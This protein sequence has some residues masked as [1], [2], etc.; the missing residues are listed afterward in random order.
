MKKLLLAGIFAIVQILPQ[1]YAANIST[2]SQATATL[3]SSC[4]LSATGI[5]FGNLTPSGASST[6][7][8]STG[9]LFVTC[10]TNTAY[11]IAQDLGVNGN[12]SIGRRMKG[13]ANGDYYG[14]VICKSSTTAANG[15]CNSGQ[16]WYNSNIYSGVGS[17]S[18][19][20]IPVY[21]FAT[22]TYLSPDNYSDTITA[23]LSF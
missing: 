1:A 16:F 23:T 11:S 3:N 4:R 22:P 21:G 9:H 7:I 2:I 17:G 15:N 6:Q 20:D 19:Q 18:E 8:T 12:I 5:D 10:T 13:S 14:Y